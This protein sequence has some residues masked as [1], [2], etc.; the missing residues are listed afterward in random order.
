MKTS[1][2][3]RIFVYA[4]VAL[5][6][7]SVLIWGIGNNN[8]MNFFS[9]NIS[10]L[11][12]GSGFS[13]NDDNYKIGDGEVPKDQVSEIEVN[14]TA[15][16]VTIAPTM[17]DE[18]TDVISFTEESGTQL[19]EDYELRYKLE[20]GVLKIMFA[21]PNVKFQGI[22]QSLNKDLVIHVPVG[23]ELS[24]ITIDTV[25]ANIDLESITATNQFNLATV[26][27]NIDGTQ[28]IADVMAAETVSG[29]IRWNEATLRTV[30]AESVS[31]EINVSF[32]T[33]PTNIQMETVSGAMTL[34]LPENEGFKVDY[35][36]VS[37]DFDCD[38]DVRI[39]KNMAMY[40][41]GVNKIDLETVSGNMK[42]LS[43]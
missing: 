20:D 21:K 35:D 19:D 25:S 24:D 2:L 12:G 18:A 32:L 37:G 43:I 6:L 11:F 8:N 16:N 42:I 13:Y 14:W 1:A 15:G 39:N 29:K 31:G 27:G 38:F 26:S 23:T 7:T 30:S 3:I 28:I 4:F 17:G 33:M 9:F 5:V 22:F 40:K 34:G 10:N 36:K 41:N